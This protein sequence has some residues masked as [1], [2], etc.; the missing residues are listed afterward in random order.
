MSTKRKVK[1]PVGKQTATRPTAT[2]NP[3]PAKRGAAASNKG[4][5]MRYRAGSSKP[6]G[7]GRKPEF[8]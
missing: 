4:A 1:T 2:A 5:P 3:K 8:I 7:R 6:R